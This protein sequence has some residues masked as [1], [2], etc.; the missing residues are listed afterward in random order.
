MGHQIRPHCTTGN[1]KSS[2]ESSAIPRTLRPFMCLQF[3]SRFECAVLCRGRLQ[4]ERQRGSCFPRLNL[5]SRSF[6]IQNGR[7]T[8]TQGCFSAVRLIQHQTRPEHS[9]P[10]FFQSRPTASWVFNL[11][12]I[13]KIVVAVR[14]VLNAREL[15]AVLANERLVAQNAIGCTDPTKRTPPSSSVQRE[16]VLVE[17]HPPGQ[18]LSELFTMQGYRPAEVNCVRCTWTRF[19]GCGRA[20]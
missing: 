16:G 4:T 11:P 1:K 10:R 14:T 15:R 17:P 13:A 8:S 7:V 9:T 20:D 2:I 12:N 6:L 5:I 3:R 18:T 19:S